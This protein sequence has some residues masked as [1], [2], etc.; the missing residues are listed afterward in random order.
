MTGKFGIREDVSDLKHDYV[1]HM[2]LSEFLTSVL[3]YLQHRY[4]TDCYVPLPP[5][6]CKGTIG[7]N[8]AMKLGYSYSFLRNWVDFLYGTDFHYTDDAETMMFRIGDS[9]N[10]HP[11]T[12]DAILTM[13]WVVKCICNYVRTA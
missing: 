1:A 8:D 6:I 12:D 3:A 9:V 5:E 4:R 11:A 10:V 2:K 7:L 13:L